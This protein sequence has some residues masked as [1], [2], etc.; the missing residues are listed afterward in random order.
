MKQSFQFLWTSQ[1]FANLGDVLYIVGFISVLY[2]HDATATTLALLPFLNVCG[3]MI[4]S[5]VAPLLFNRYRLKHLLVTTQLMKTILLCVLIW[6]PFELT[7]LFTVVSC[8]AL[9][10]GVA[11]P[12]SSALVPRL[13]SKEALLRANAILSIANQSTQLGGWALGGLFVAATSGKIAVFTTAILFTLSTVCLICLKDPQPFQKRTLAK[14]SDELIEG[15]A[16]IWRHRAM[17]TIHIVFVIESFAGVVWIAAIMYIFVADVLHVS[18]AWWGYINT[19]FFIGL[20]IGAMVCTKYETHFNQHVTT[21]IIRSSLCAAVATLLFG[22]NEWPLL[23]LVLSIIF[24]LFEEM[25]GQL[26]TT[27]IQLHTTE[28]VLAQVYSA[29]SVLNYIAFGSA[30]LLVG[31]LAECIAIQSI[32]I[33][34]GLLLLISTI[35]LYSMKRRFQ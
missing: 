25:K 16:W 7:L 11:Q 29:Q 2:H 1:L 6:V 20:F 32:F 27:W 26:M 14:K 9:L 34:A 35:Y 19:A 3:R 28:H 18:E 21:W 17:R 24:G 33:G 8:I 23:A 13:V 5:S 22:W 30:T 15:F 31:Y 12:A 10:D 4:S